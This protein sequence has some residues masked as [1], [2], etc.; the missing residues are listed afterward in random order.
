[1]PVRFSIQHS[2]DQSTNT[3]VDGKSLPFDGV[4]VNYMATGMPSSMFQTFQPG[5]K[6]TTSVNA[7]KTHNLAGL[8]SAK[9]S[10]VQGFRYVTGTTAPTALKD[11]ESCNASS[12]TVSI[13]PDQSKVVA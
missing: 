6:F 11:T 1:M 8:T 5:E 13:V 10:V 7:A 9:V 12:K 4:A 2:L 3:S